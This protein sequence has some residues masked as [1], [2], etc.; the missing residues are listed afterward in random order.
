MMVA[1]IAQLFAVSTRRLLQL[2]D[3]GRPLAGPQASNLAELWDAWAHAVQ[4]GN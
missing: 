3:R 4:I 1:R 2:G